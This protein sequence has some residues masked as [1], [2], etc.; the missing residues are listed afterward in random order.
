M[1][2]NRLVIIMAMNEIEVLLDVMLTAQK[3]EEV[4]AG[5]LRFEDDI[6]LIEHMRSL[7]GNKDLKRCSQEDLMP[8]IELLE[9]VVLAARRS[10]PN[11]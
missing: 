3:S 5:L 2:R 4:K 11:I 9:T 10:I 1:S 7:L 6:F 8:V